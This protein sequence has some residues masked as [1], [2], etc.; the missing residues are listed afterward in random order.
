[1]LYLCELIDAVSISRWLADY[2]SSLPTP[3]RTRDTRHD[4]SPQR[5]A[6]KPAAVRRRPGLTFAQQMSQHGPGVGMGGGMRNAL[7][8]A[9]P[10]IPSAENDE[11]PFLV[12]PPSPSE[13]PIRSS[14]VHFIPTALPSPPPTERVRRIVHKKPTLPVDQESNPFYCPPGQAS[15]SA[16]ASSLAKAQRQQARQ[17]MEESET[18]TYVQYVSRTVR[19]LSQD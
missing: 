2:R 3:P 19:N 14:K 15:T 8:P 4:S 1:M 10:I 12:T 16:S 11:N 18:I 17:R 6:C 5:S 9:A 13:T 7:I